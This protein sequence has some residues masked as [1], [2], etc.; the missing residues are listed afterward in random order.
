MNHRAIAT[1]VLAL[2]LAAGGCERGEDAPEGD[3]PD[4]LDVDVPDQVEEGVERGARQL[5]GKVGE[6]LEETGEAIEEAGE[7]L[8]EE[9]GEPAVG[10]DSL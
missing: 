2:A 5:G 4:T 10:G 6:A 1:L 9:A 8:Q 3:E 7:R